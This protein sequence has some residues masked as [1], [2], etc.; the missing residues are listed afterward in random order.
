MKYSKEALNRFGVVRGTS[1]ED[2]GLIYYKMLT[3]K[4][5]EA[6]T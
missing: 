4:E 2:L 3:L 6:Q 5:G 1:N